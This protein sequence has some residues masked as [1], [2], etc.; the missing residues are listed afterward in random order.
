MRL[1]LEALFAVCKSQDLV[2]VKSSVFS[3]KCDLDSD[4][5]DKAGGKK[6]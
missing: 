6:F 3:F 5:S 4:L 2:G 1:I